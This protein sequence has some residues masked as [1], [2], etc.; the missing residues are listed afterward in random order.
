MAWNFL[1]KLN[2]H[3]QNNTAIL[4]L[5]VYQKERKVYVHVQ[6]QK[7]G[8]ALLVKPENQHNPNAL[9]SWN[10]TQLLKRNILTIPTTTWMTTSKA[11]YCT[12]EASIKRHATCLHLGFPRGSGGKEHACNAG[13]PSSIQGSGRPLEKRMATHSSIPAWRIPWTE[14]PGR[15]QS[16]GSQRVGHT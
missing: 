11:F 16:V 10:P 1:R 3:L 6:T 15:L 7:F 9:N 13:D 14:T 2:R 12:N 4:L 8:A 5:D